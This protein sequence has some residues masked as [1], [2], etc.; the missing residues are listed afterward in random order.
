MNDAVFEVAANNANLYIGMLVVYLGVMVAIG[1]YAHRKTKHAGEYYI[2]GRKI[3]HFL[4]LCG[5]C[6]TWVSATSMIGGP[7]WLFRFGYNYLIFAPF[8]WFV[9]AAVILIPIGYKIRRV[10]LNT[11]PELM[12]SRYNSRTLQLMMGIVLMIVFVL[13][14]TIQ[15]TGIGILMS[16][17][18][19][20]PFET[21]VIF[22][23]VVVLY[24]AI[25][26]FK[27]VILTDVLNFALII[28]GVV[29]GAV[30]V[31]NMTGGLTAINQ[32]AMHI[33]THPMY[34]ADGAGGFVPAPA[35]VPGSLLHPTAMST[36]APF[37]LFGVFIANGIGGGT[38]AQYIIRAIAAKNNKVAI[39]MA[40]FAVLLM[41]IVYFLS[42]IIGM[43]ARVIMPTLPVGTT[44]DWI[45]PLLCVNFFSPFIGGLIM[46]ALCAGAI[47]SAN[48][49]ILLVA[50]S[51]IYDVYKAKFN[52][53]LSG[54]KL[55]LSTRI[56]ALVAGGVAMY[57]VLDPPEAVVLLL[58]Y[59]SGLNASTVFAPIWLGLFWKGATKEG[60]IASM[61]I[62]GISFFLWDYFDIN[63]A[64][65]VHPVLIGMGLAVLTMVVVSKNTKP[66]ELKYLLPYFP[67]LRQ[68]ASKEELDE[69]L[70]HER[71][72]GAIGGKIQTTR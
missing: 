25:L 64:T 70:A 19:G 28:V 27:S 8:A 33:D 71:F 20:I 18:L 13:F 1:Y 31:L 55:V 53:E 35:T 7:G 21:G 46:V 6:A 26:G 32:A 65:G 4:T 62:G 50:T 45:Y 58:A 66:T 42:A 17:M 11:V 9:G 12:Y 69:A 54:K 60:A 59:I 37:F 3:G 36:F 56:A 34:F 51:A 23:A 63:I 39:M 15:M 5:F 10:P 67:Y 22:V 30:L 43:G 49:Q 41:M 68:T 24:T 48:T 29:I 44:Q 14:S 72:D 40:G 47:S 2:G 52:K 38:N 57:I 16:S 61:L